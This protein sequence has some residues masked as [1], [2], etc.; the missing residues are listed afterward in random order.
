M[1][2]TRHRVV[3]AEIVV[4]RQEIDVV[5]D[6]VVTLVAAQE[7][8]DVQERGTVEPTQF[9]WKCSK[10]THSKVHSNFRHCMWYETVVTYESTAN[11]ESTT[12]SCRW[13]ESPLQMFC[14]DSDH[15]IS[16]KVS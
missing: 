9:V 2:G 1:E 10:Y 11:T 14:S 16:L 7:K 4:E 8:A 6:H 3:V 13:V 15:L 5:H 12:E